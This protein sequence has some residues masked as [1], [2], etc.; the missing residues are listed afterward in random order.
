MNSGFSFRAVEAYAIV[1]KDSDYTDSEEEEAAVD[2]LEH[3]GIV[4][5]SLVRRSM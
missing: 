1:D 5:L 2:L 4:G 3:R